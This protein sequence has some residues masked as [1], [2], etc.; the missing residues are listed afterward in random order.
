MIAPAFKSRHS[1]LP[2][3]PAAGHLW[4]LVICKMLF[5]FFPYI[6]IV[7]CGQYFFF[8][9]PYLYR[10]EWGSER[11]HSMPTGTEWVSKGDWS[12]SIWPPHLCSHLPLSFLFPVPLE[13]LSLW[14]FFC[15]HSPERGLTGIKWVR[16]QG[17]WERWIQPQESVKK[18]P[19]ETLHHSAL[20]CSPL[21]LGG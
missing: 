8:Y 15:Y 10:W 7:L 13:L 4:T 9:Y 18:V 19:G 16:T 17:E 11:L 3:C 6:S 1:D 12:Q 2:G 14:W 20:K 5:L 21:P